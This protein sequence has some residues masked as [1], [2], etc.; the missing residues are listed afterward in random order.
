[1]AIKDL[2]NL[3]ELLNYVGYLIKIANIGQRF[4]WKSVLKYDEEY[5]KAQ[6]ESGF[7]FGADNSYMMQLFL[8]DGPALGKPLVS[9][10][11]KPFSSH[12]H[13]RYDPGSGKPIC[14]RFNTPQGCSMHSCKFAHV[15]RTCY[16]PHSD[17][18][19]KSQHN[20]ATELPK[21]D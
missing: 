15:C 8:R 17:A 13:T 12:P 9:S 1:M 6:A 7:R 5:R 4:Q 21:N 11:G 20:A 16:K 10:G 18:T 2:L 3:P 14:G 19:H